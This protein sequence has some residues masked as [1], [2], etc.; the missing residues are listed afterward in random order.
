MQGCASATLAGGAIV[1][2]YVQ[3]PEEGQHVLIP[4]ITAIPGVEGQPP[5]CEKGICPAMF[6]AQ[7]TPVIVGIIHEVAAIVD[8]CPQQ[9]PGWLRGQARID[10]LRLRGWY[11][12]ERTRA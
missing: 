12:Q 10:R 5:L 3:C 8:Q 2:H 11:G 1:A 9:T 6:S 4:H 7:R